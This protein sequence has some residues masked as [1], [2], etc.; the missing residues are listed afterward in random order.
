MLYLETVTG[1]NSGNHI[2][3]IIMST[4]SIFL[5]IL[6]ILIT[7][8]DSDMDTLQYLMVI[9]GSD[10]EGYRTGEVGQPNAERIA[11]GIGAGEFL[12]QRY[13]GYLSES[14]M[15][16]ELYVH[17]VDT[18]ACLVNAYVGNMP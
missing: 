5:M 1:E 6:L 10:E 3:T 13:R 17:S 12:R 11:Q 2:R 15:S 18:D 9:H 7:V 14:Y 16:T 8:S 4:F